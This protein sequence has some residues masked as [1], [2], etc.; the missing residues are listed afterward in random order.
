MET[1]ERCPR[2]G[3]I[4]A[5]G[6]EP[7]GIEFT[8]MRCGACG[9]EEVCD[10]WQMTMEWRETVP[11]AR[12]RGDVRSV[13]PGDRF[14]AMWKKLGAR[15]HGANVLERLRDAYDEAHRA[16][17]TA[18]H[19]GACR[20]LLDDP[21]VSGLAERPVEV[22]AALWFH[23]VVYDT[24]AADNEEK[25]AVWAEG[26]L[27]L[28]GVDPHTIARVADHVRATRSHC[29]STADGQLVV[30]ID[31]SILGVEAE[32][33]DRFEE[34]IR[35][36]Y[37]WVDLAAYKPGRAEVLRRFLDRPFIYATSVLRERYE[38]RARNNLERALRALGVTTS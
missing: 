31:L 17:H 29:A 33:F 26:S 20:A 7:I 21:A 22:E 18:R 19:V 9:Y 27:R 37:D 24:R 25:S 15:E 5:G 8:R 10:V 6:V 28:A 1:V 13:L 34:E 16:Y 3:S 23:D 12:V 2:C 30:D 4:D 11:K 35:R 14:L 36:E 32:A 38:Q